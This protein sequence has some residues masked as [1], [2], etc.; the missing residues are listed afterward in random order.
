M[1][2]SDE[3]EAKGIK[4]EKLTADEKQT[5][6]TMLDAVRESQLSVE[7]LRDYIISMRSAVEQEL[8]NTELG[9]D[10]DLFLKA[11]LKNYMLLESFLISPEKAKKAYDDMVATIREKVK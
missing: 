4:I 7:K 10:Q 11:R 6:F 2:V 9:V 3:I 1:S 5:Y 8:I